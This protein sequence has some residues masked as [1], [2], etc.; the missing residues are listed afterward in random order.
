[1]SLINSLAIVDDDRI[2]HLTSSK[3]IEKSGL[4]KEILPFKNG[5]EALNFILQNKNNEH[6]LPE[7]ILL[8][9]N[10]P[11]L[12]GWGFLEEFKKVKHTVNK[13]VTI[14]ITSSSTSQADKEKAKEYDCVSKYLTK[15][16]SRTFFSTV[17]E[18][19]LSGKAS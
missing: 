1:M 17:L 7:L 9:L 19:Y 10:M 14:Y 4:V 15:P 13:Q 5:E 3:A 12:D 8:D 6:Q 16:I 18:E 11:V 2:F